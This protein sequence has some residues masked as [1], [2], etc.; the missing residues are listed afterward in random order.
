MS[1][2]SNGTSC[3]LVKDRS[4]KNDMY[5]D[6]YRWLRK[7]GFSSWGKKGYF[8]DVD[9]VYI[10]INSMTFAPGMPGI[11][12]T[13]VVGNHAITF[14][15]FK[16]IYSIYKQYEGLDVLRLSAEEQLA[17]D[18]RKLRERTLSS[19][20]SL[21]GRVYIYLDSSETAEIFSRNIVEEGFCKSFT[22]TADIYAL[23]RD[24]AYSVGFAGHMAFAQ[25][26][27][28][29]DDLLIRVDYKKYISG[30]DFIIRK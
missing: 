19:L 13:S 28:I 14:D 29:G 24:G 12:V 3:F 6:I 15:E 4:L 17:W 11:S 16:K 7:E 2:I 20:L 27:K 25:A 8:S 30:E 10:N 26:D 9:W 18:V 21:K 5:A 22:A 23:H 1:D